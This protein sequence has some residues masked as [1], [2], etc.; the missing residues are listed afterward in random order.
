M[1]CWFL[2]MIPCSILAYSLF[3]KDKAFSDWLSWRLTSNMKYCPVP[4]WVWISELNWSMFVIFQNKLINHGKEILTLKESSLVITHIIRS[5]VHLYQ[6]IS[7]IR[8]AMA[9]VCNLKGVSPSNY[10]LTMARQLR[11]MHIIYSCLLVCIS[12]IKCPYHLLY[13]WLGQHLPLR[14]HLLT[15][16]DVDAVSPN[17]T[18]KERA[19]LISLVTGF[20]ISL[21]IQ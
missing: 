2:S 10:G 9:T 5:E 18:H 21:W 15:L 19:N 6:C 20:S 12:F 17:A 11:H 13:W 7:D 8:R 4:K 16:L 14:L 3:E 1:C